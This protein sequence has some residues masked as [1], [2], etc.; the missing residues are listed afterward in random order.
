MAVDTWIQALS[1]PMPWIEHYLE[2]FIGYIYDSK[3]KPCA[4]RRPGCLVGG[5]KR[6]LIT[7][8]QYL[9]PLLPYKLNSQNAIKTARKQ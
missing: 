3:G 7:N 2:E 6:A 5:E 1:I 4:A 9:D 8:T